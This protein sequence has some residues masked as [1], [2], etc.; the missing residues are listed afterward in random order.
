MSKTICFLGGPKDQEIRAVENNITRV[1]FCELPNL[2]DSPDTPI[3]LIY[4][5]YLEAFENAPYFQ[6]HGKVSRHDE[7]FDP[8]AQLF[9]LV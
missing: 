5:V 4:H 8:Y 3:E 9:P 6:Y 2:R 1:E 7:P